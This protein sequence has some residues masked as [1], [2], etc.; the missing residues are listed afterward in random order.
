MRVNFSKVKLRQNPVTYKG[1]YAVAFKTKPG[2][3]ARTLIKMKRHAFAV[4]A[5]K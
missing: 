3:A 4:H 1:L 2:T 5:E